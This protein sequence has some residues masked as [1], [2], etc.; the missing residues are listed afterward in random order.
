MLPY[1]IPNKLS[2]FFLIE[3]FTGFVKTKNPTNMNIYQ[4]GFLHQWHYENMND[5]IT[6]RSRFALLRNVTNMYQSIRG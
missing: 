6:H 2:I 5:I 3:V 1:Y 4:A